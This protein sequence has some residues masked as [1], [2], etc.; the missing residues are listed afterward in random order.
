[1]IFQHTIDKVLSGEK[2][3]TR[4]IVKPTH[5][6]IIK[7]S[8]AIDKFEM[9]S[10]SGKLMVK[11]PENIASQQPIVR[12]ESNDRSLYEVGKTYAIQPGRGMKAV[13]RI[14]IVSIRREDVRC[15]SLADVKAEGF[16]TVDD[17]LA[18][19]VLMHDKRMLLQKDNRLPAGFWLFKEN[20]ATWNGVDYGLLAV[21]LQKR[22]AEKYQAWVLE[23]KLVKAS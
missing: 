19:W 10:E 21:A 6:D 11:L 15:I 1:M 17:F 7:W 14:E 18:T 20:G 5:T 13:G 3:Q 22:S 12:I 4:R 23:F 16:D 8:M 9:S 2:T